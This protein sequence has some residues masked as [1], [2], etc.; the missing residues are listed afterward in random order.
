MSIGRG[1][2]KNSRDWRG[3]SRG[4]VENGDSH[5]GLTFISISNNLMYFLSEFSNF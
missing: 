4:K 5:R 3:G 2:E 1:K